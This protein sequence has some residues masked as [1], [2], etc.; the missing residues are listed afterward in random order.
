M[1]NTI[2]QV[3]IACF[4]TWMAGTQLAGAATFTTVGD[5]DWELSGTWDL[6]SVPTKDDDIIVKHFVYLNSNLTVNSTL[7]IHADGLLNL[8]GQLTVKRGATFTN[9]GGMIAT[10]NIFN[11]GTIVNNDSFFMDNGANITNNAGAVL[12]SHGFTKIEGN[13]IDNGGTMNGTG[14]Y[15][16]GGNVNINNKNSKIEGGVY[17]CIKKDFHISNI[18]SSVNCDAFINVEGNVINNGTITGTGSIR[19]MKNLVNKGT[20]PGTLD[21]CVVGSITGAAGVVS[22]C[23]N[24]IFPPITDT[25]AT[26][27]LTM[28]S[29]IIPGGTVLPIELLSFT[30]QGMDNYVRLKWSTAVE[31][32]N[33]YFMVQRT[34]NGITWEDLGKV[35]G[36]GN[37]NSK[38][39]YFY[40]DKEPYEG[41]AYYAL[42]QVDTDGGYT[43]LEP[44]PITF[45]A[46][47]EESCTFKVKPN[48]CPSR[49]N[50]SLAGCDAEVA[51]IAVYDVMGRQVT[52][53]VPTTSGSGFFIDAQNNLAP[54]TYIVFG[55]SGDK[56]VSKKILVQ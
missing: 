26:C 33:E 8:T 29:S 9:N 3:L 15:V 39:D 31:I 43:D 47:D 51:N 49:C 52:T 17:F 18:F 28:S 6:G 44:I 20:L 45:Q 36:A 22:D 12:T 38:K 11:W 56:K 50:V 1:R 35:L 53:Q 37:S 41:T 24:P 4:L 16:V 34:R 14:N 30:G 13:I 54:G 42:R 55:T 27:F 32:N 7:T 19:T 25:C 2:A 10:A 21:W 48:P 5:G 23:A 46:T 40:D